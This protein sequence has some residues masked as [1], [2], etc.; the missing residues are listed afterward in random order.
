M[1]TEVW[2]HAHILTR[3]FS[4]IFSNVILAFYVDL[5]TDLSWGILNLL[6]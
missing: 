5:W 6:V 4:N 3:K 2:F 1:D